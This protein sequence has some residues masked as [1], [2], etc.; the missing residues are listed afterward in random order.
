MDMVDVDGLNNVKYI[1]I[2]YLFIY[3]YIY[4]LVILI[5]FFVCLYIC[6]FG[7]NLV[8]IDWFHER[9]RC[10]AFPLTIPMVIL[11]ECGRK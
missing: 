10:P 7:E 4:L 2:Y 5:Y 3:L 6:F 1:Y 8:F 9:F 11:I